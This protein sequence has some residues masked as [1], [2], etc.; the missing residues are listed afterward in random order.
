MPAGFLILNQKNTGVS[1]AR[2]NGVALAKYK[3]IAFLDADDWWDQK[4]LSEMAVL[5]KKYP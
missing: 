2:N 3:Y 4:F 1:T 5:I